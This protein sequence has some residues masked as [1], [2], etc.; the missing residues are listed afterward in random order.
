MDGRCS[1]KHVWTGRSIGCVG[2]RE[3]ARDGKHTEH[4]RHAT[5][6]PLPCQFQNTVPYGA[7]S[8][9][10]FHFMSGPK[11]GSI[12]CQFQSTVPFRASSKARF[13]LMPVPKHG[14]IW[15][16]F[17][18][19]VPN[20][21]TPG[22]VHSDEA[23]G[24]SRPGHPT[25]QQP[26][27]SQAAASAVLRSGQRDRSDGNQRPWACPPAA[28][29]ER[30]AAMTRR[31]PHMCLR[32][33]R[34][35]LAAEHAPLGTRTQRAMDNPTSHGAVERGT[36][37]EASKRKA[38]SPRLKVL[39]RQRACST[40]CAPQTDPSRLLLWNGNL[41]IALTASAKVRKPAINYVAC[42]EKQ[43]RV[44][45]AAVSLR[46]RL[47]HERRRRW[48]RKLLKSPARHNYSAQYTPHQHT[49]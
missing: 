2:S 48:S 29:T 21:G 5:L 43:C 39:A 4:S 49:R 44:Y 42:S 47:R 20:D 16:Q 31:A 40:F 26:M 1:K 34:P 7:S 30:T 24:D 36:G 22:W 15:C 13:H 33:S 11:H 9:A 6:T 25:G 17:Q 28:T 23:V 12:S 3:E 32:G 19:S 8:K 14:S 38:A 45:C 35:M 10:P 27:L 18:N 37:T 46:Q 41:A